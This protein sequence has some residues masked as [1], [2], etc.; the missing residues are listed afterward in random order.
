MQRFR[1][2]VKGNVRFGEGGTE[3]GG[4]SIRQNTSIG[5]NRSGRKM[6]NY[7]IPNKTDYIGERLGRY[8][9]KGK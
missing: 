9:G 1:R 3:D 4:T 5:E 8:K 7:D 6:E 2:C